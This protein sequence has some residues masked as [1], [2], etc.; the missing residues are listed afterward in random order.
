MTNLGHHI[1]PSRN[2]RDRAAQLIFAGAA[3]AAMLA[4]FGAAQPA[5]TATVFASGPSA[6]APFAT[7]DTNFVDDQGQTSGDI[8]TQ[9]AQDQN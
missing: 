9:N 7:D 3:T 1:K 4:L 8:F 6:T 2:R 5:G